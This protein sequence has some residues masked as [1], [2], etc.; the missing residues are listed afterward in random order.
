MLGFVRWGTPVCIAVG[1]AV[2]LLG[3][4]RDFLV[5]PPFRCFFPCC[6]IVAWRVRLTVW[7]NAWTLTPHDMGYE[8]HED[9]AAVLLDQLDKL[10]TCPFAMEP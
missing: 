10:A 6:C 1:E 3:G 4:T 9:W 7:V 8:I 2:W 5:P